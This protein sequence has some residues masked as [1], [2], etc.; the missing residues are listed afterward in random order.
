MHYFVLDLY[1]DKITYFQPILYIGHKQYDSL[2]AL[3]FTGFTCDPLH[4]IYQVKGKE[5]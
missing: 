1:Y 5:G 2:I 3:Y 4:Y